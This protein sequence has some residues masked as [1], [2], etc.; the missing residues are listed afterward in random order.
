[1]VE[2]RKSIVSEL[3]IATVLALAI[4]LGADASRPGDNPCSV[5]KQCVLTGRA[6]IWPFA[7]GQ[8]AR[9]DIP[10]GCVTIALPEESYDK[11]RRRWNGKRVRVSGIARLQ[12]KDPVIYYYIEGRRVSGG[13][14]DPLVIVVKDIK[15]LSN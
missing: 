5:G 15:S 14:C 12:P 10:L 4:L 9:L 11:L 1:M 2:V 7:D 6:T 8:E 13:M 3:R